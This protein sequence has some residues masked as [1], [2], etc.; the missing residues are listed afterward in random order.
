MNRTD[1]FLLTLVCFMV[2]YLPIA[3]ASA[4]EVIKTQM[5]AIRIVKIVSGL[6]H[7]WGH[8]FLPDGRILVTER[9]GRLRPR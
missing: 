4:S 7:P 1:S 5:H 9:P 8:A 6:E 3:A 2:A